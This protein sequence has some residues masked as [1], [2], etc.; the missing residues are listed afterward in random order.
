M[1]YV[2]N[3][4]MPNE[5]RLRNECVYCWRIEEELS[6]GELAKLFD[7]T[8]QRASQICSRIEKKFKEG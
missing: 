3:G 2:D 5:Q 8:R 7:M 6:F 1:V 4:N